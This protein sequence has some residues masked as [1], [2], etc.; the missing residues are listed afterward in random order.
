[1]RR[2]GRIH[3]SIAVPLFLGLGLQVMTLPVYGQGTPQTVTTDTP[4]YCLQLLDRV[5][6]L[7]RMAE[8]PPQEATEL[9]AEGE[10]MC[11]QGQT[12]GGILR[13]RRALVLL[14]QKTASGR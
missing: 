11:N 6:D 9:S 3:A 10:R 7:V 2:A 12:L 4:E 8:H 1:M 14:T 13:L 5:S